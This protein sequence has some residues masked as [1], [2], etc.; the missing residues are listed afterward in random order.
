MKY[1]KIWHQAILMSVCFSLLG[2]NSAHS[3]E[4]SDG[5]ALVVSDWHRSAEIRRRPSYATPE[6]YRAFYIRAA[7]SAM[8][9]PASVLHRKFFVTEHEREMSFSVGDTRDGYMVNGRPLPAP[10]LLLRQLPVQYER[11]LAY[12]T[13]DMVELF[14]DTARAMEKKYP[15]TIMYL[16]N[17][18]AREGG[19][20]PYSV[21]HN[22]GR[23]ADIG[24]YLKDAEGK[25]AHPQNLHKI[26]RRFQS[27]E[28][29]PVYTFDL[30]KNTTLIELLLT[31]PKVRV[32]F[33]FLAK[34]L[35]TAIYRELVARGS[36]PELLERFEMSVQNQAAHDDHFH[37]RIYCS[38]SDICAGCVDKSVI[39]PWHE[40]PLPKREQCVARYASM[41]KKNKTEPESKAVALQRLALLGAAS[42][43]ESQ[44]IKHLG[45][46]NSEVRLAA[47]MAAS[48]LSSG[49]TQALVKQLAKE[50]Q[51]SVR[52][53]L[54]QTLS[55][56]D[57]AQTRQTFMEEIVRRTSQTDAGF[58]DEEM[59]TIFHFIIRHPHANNAKPLLDAMHAAARHALSDTKAFEA[60]AHTFGVVVNM[61]VKPTLAEMLAHADAWFAEHGTQTRQQWLIDGFKREGFQVTN[62]ENAD[63]P[64]LLDAIDGPAEISLNAQ[65]QLKKIS[66]L[67]QDSLSWPVADARWHY[68]R[69]FKRRAKKFRIDLSD[70][71]ERGIKFVATEE[72]SSSQKN[73]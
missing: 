42:A 40:D 8:R 12:A 53:A 55:G 1:R 26:N 27:R 29:G 2:C 50:S 38:N 71:N 43:N 10:S 15:G 20:I 52:L 25:F 11:G 23:D 49:V 62:L 61:A 46:E 68:T 13:T 48:E 65:L 6:V 30:E 7:E 16:G 36:S 24:F 63:I 37:V 17:M 21:S 57:T 35:R 18:A 14:V 56:F 60:V 64:I 58:A 69:Y 31:H 59:Q 5:E 32:Q 39:H 51:P 67:K 54:I 3:G 4:L 34:H 73:P 22:A 41:L 44:I 28:E 45:H 33:I 72:N 47:A 70:R 19:D 9:E 66:R